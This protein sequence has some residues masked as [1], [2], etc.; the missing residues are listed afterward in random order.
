MYIIASGKLPTALKYD[1]RLPQSF[2]TSTLEFEQL[3]NSNRESVRDL[4]Q[5]TR[6]GKL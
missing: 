5:L 3:Q 4:L 6:T 2:S 1:S